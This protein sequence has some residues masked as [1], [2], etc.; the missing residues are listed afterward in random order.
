MTLPAARRLLYSR[1]VTTTRSIFGLQLV[2]LSIVVMTFALAELARGP[3]QTRATILSMIGWATF[4]VLFLTWLWEECGV[5]TGLR[6][7]GRITVLSA[8]A[9]AVLYLY[10]RRSRLLEAGI[11]VD[12][13][14]TFLGVR[15]FTSL[16][17]PITFAGI[18]MSF[19]QFPM[20]LLG[21]LPAY[22]VGFDRLGPFA[23]HVAIMLQV[24][25]LLALLTTHVLDR[26]LLVQA[27]TVAAVA[28]VFSNRFTVLLCNLTGYAIP[29]VSIGIIF[30][31]TVLGE[32]SFSVMAPRVGGLLMLSLM[33]HYPGFFF[34]LPLVGLWVVAGRAPW[35]RFTTFLRANVPLCATVLVAAASV[36]I[37]PEL[38]LPRL[39]EVTEPN[40]TLDDFLV[41]VSENWDHLWNYFPLDFVQMFFRESVGSWHLLNIPPLGGLL[42]PI[43]LA[44]WVV[45]A[46]AMGRRGVVYGARLVVLGTCLVV[47]T[48]LQHVLTDFANYRDM[49]L[50]LGM[51]T[52]GVGFV[53]LAPGAHAVL[54]P[55]LIGYGVAVA[56]YG[57]IDVAQL[58]GR[59][60]AVPEYAP[61]QQA[62]MEALRQ[63]WRHREG[64]RGAVVD[65]VVTEPFPLERLYEDAA[66]EHGITLRFVAADAFCKDPVATVEDVL[67][68]A[69]GRVAFALPATT[70]AAGWQQLGWPVAR[71]AGGMA[72]YLFESACGS[73]SPR[74]RSSPEVI[75]LS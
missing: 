32:Q 39:Q 9:F 53:L 75:D 37:H 29:S 63:F 72:I 7:L 3:V 23:I 38:L 5:R 55:V 66:R 25:M 54:R 12:A 45:T 15:W 70:C 61:A 71:T 59:R 48:A 13:T 20:A 56:A 4:L 1:R 19:A 10:Y 60:Y 52:P 26:T 74:D 65:A 31:V 28:A 22:L 6:R 41:K 64:L 47:L 35:R 21:H 51:M 69:C 11:E 14:Y 68:S 18:T 16:E 62:A 17:N 40:L 50:L 43:V 36:G 73:S 2:L 33:H 58:A 67:D 30:L 46:V 24:A 8:V 42:G 49:T 27:V 57:Y 44:N 34:V